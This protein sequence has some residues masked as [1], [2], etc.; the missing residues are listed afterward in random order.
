MANLPTNYQDD[1]LDTSQNTNRKYRMIENQDGT[2]SFEDV[3]E[4]LQNGSQLGASGINAQNTEINA[5]NT[6]KIA[7][8]T[9][10]TG[11]VPV[12]FVGYDSTN[13]KLGLKVNGADTV[14]PFSGSKG[15][16]VLNQQY[17]NTGNTQ[18]LSWTTDKDYSFIYLIGFAATSFYGKATTLT[19]RHTG[20]TQLFINDSLPLG[21][22]S[23]TQSAT[24]GYG[25][26][27]M[28]YRTNVPRGTALSMSFNF[29]GSGGYVVKAFKVL[30][31]E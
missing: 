14:I 20:G 7:K 25:A 29:G 11:Y 24:I 15:L 1:I 26:C 30:G 6:S 16:T 3:T 5:L 2:V 22:P 18:T 28:Y 23:S 12:D 4:Y 9:D 13:K 8:M 19:V 21:Y 27:A 17:V 10:V 31:I